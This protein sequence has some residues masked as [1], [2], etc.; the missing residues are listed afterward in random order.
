MP[1]FSMKNLATFLS[2]RWTP[3]R[4][5]F[6]AIGKKNGD[7][8]HKREPIPLFPVFKPF[9]PAVQWW[10]Y[11]HPVKQTNSL[12]VETPSVSRLLERIC[13]DKDYRS[14]KCIGNGTCI[15]EEINVNHV[16]T[17]YCFSR[18]FPLFLF[19]GTKLSRETLRA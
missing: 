4:C 1:D 19:R 14:S 10:F 7:A 11:E 9:V 6:N 2:A 3:S 12:R 15:F 13:L 5:L 17:V 8:C 18:L 16:T